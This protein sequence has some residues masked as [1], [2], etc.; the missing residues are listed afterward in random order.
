[1]ES[2]MVLDVDAR[3]DLCGE[4][5]VVAHQGWVREY[6]LG[7]IPARRWLGPWRYYCAIHRNI[8]DSSHLERSRHDQH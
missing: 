3:C 2:R 4:E 6:L 7:F 5:S 1:M 8:A